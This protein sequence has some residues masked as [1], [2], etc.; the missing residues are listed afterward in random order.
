M[1]YKMARYH[2]NKI[3]F[4]SLYPNNLA[5]LDYNFRKKFKEVKGF[6]LPTKSPTIRK[7]GYFCVSCGLQSS[8]GSR[9]CSSCGNAIP[10]RLD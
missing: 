5:N 7:S 9:F 1:K 3:D 2:E 10:Q 6:D 4:V 8:P